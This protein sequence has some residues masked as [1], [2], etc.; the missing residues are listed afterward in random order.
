MPSNE[1][2][3]LHPKKRERERDKKSGDKKS[4]YYKGTACP[5]L[6]DIVASLMIIDLFFLSHCFIN[7]KMLEKL[8]S[9]VNYIVLFPQGALVANYPWDGTE[10]KK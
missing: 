1:I 9:G 5:V 8:T 7:M 3:I 10:D 6:Y 2:S 4:S